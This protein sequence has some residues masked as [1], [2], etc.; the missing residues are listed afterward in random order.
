MQTAT[1]TATSPTVAATLPGFRGSLSDFSAVQL[2]AIAKAQT[3]QSM[4][5]NI[6]Y[7][8]ED[9]QLFT[10]TERKAAAASVA[11]CQCVAQL[12]R[13]FRNVSRLERHRGA[14]LHEA[15][16]DGTYY[17]FSANA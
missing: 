17:S 1:I 11:N 15:S 4:R 3:L 8:V 5:A 6:L 7:L 12:Q 10:D 16:T 13:W 2:Q 14:W 9:T